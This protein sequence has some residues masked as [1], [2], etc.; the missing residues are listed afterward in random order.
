M[1][2]GGGLFYDRP[3]VTIVKILN[4]VYKATGRLSEWSAMLIGWSI[5]FMTII[6]NYEVIARYGFN[7]PTVWV[8]TLS[9]MLGGLIYIVPLAHAHYHNVHV[10]IDVIYIK[11]S[12]KNRL[13]LDVFLTFLLIPIL[14]FLTKTMVWDAWTSYTIKEIAMDS[15]WHPVVWPWKMLIAFGFVNLLAIIIIKFFKDLSLITGKD[16][17]GL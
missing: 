15:P 11:L 3:Q 10:R 5:F 13:L 4:E 2:K 17:V 9:Y 16:R 8:F 12:L 1:G 6:I 7:A 14:F